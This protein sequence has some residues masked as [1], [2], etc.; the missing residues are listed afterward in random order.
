MGEAETDVN[1]H[2]NQS[3]LVDT[4]ST[5]AE[6]LTR[7]QLKASTISYKTIAEARTSKIKAMC[8]YSWYNK[9]DLLFPEGVYT[10]WL[11]ETKKVVNLMVKE[12]E[13]RKAA[14]RTVRSQTSVRGSLDVNKLHQYKYDDHLFKQVT[15]LADAKNHGMMMLVDYS[16]SMH[17]ML[18]AVLKQTITLSMFCKRVGIPFEV[19]GFTSDNGA[20]QELLKDAKKAAKHPFTNFDSDNLII[21]ELLS[22]KMPKRVYEEA[23]RSMFHQTVKPAV[24]SDLEK[25]SNTPLN[26]ALMAMKIKIEDFR[27]TNK[28]DKMSLITLT[29]GDSNHANILS[30]TSGLEVIGSRINNVIINVNGTKVEI[31]RY[32]DGRKQ[33]AQFVKVIRDMGV[34]CINYFI[35]ANSYE[36]GGELRRT[37]GWADKAGIA[38]ARGAIRKTGANI[39]DNDCGYN[40]RF[41]IDGRG[42]AM[43]GEVDD[44]NV[45]SDMTAH[46]I[47]KAFSKSNGS[48]KKSR[49]VTQKFAE[50]VG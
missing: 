47:A 35:C 27:K 7:K 10:P 8:D 24:R 16:G 46:K 29:D 4:A 6:G 14:Y 50:M 9:D 25:L 44:L 39:I 48:K 42:D 17:H 1:F 3:S 23:I 20:S 41:V 13:M 31:K 32:S 43:S 30:G 40:R 33:T 45:D 34:T 11:A 38:K 22:S 5:Y 49:I 37:Y 18:P 36:L 26:A 2:E 15:R 12:F 28:V 19:Y 21:L